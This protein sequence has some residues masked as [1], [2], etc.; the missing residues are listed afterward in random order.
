[1][2]FDYF[3]YGSNMLTERLRRRC[4][5]ANLLGVATVENWAFTFSK[6]S[7]HGCGMGT[8]SQSAGS[9]LFGVVFEI[10]E[11]ERNKLDAAEGLGYGY[12]RDDAF[13]VQ[14]RD[15]SQILI[16]TTYIANPS[17]YDLTLKP[18][19]W[20]RALV[21]AGAKQ[22]ALP[23]DYVGTLEGTASIPDSE[24]DR[25]ERLAALAILKESAPC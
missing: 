13:A 4:P 3:A 16:T 22:H 6:R 12:D 14:M 10:E 25:P 9:K 15:S 5:S 23:S 20:Y 19:D 11:R 24:L 18:F 1:M 7:K 8:I 17:H 2:N 21:I